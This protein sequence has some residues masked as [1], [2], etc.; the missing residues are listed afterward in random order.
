M[1][2]AVGGAQV[3]AREE[4]GQS[5][6]CSRRDSTTRATHGRGKPDLGLH[7]HSGCPHEPRA[8]YRTI[9]D[10]AR[11]ESAR[12]PA[13]ADS[14][15]VVADVSASALGSDHRADFFTTEVWTCEASRCSSSMI[16]RPGAYRSSGPRH[17][18]TTRYAPGC[19]DAFD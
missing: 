10:R 2:P 7:A 19:P 16:S 12:C 13:G 11:A 1:V 8:P 14:P 18:R 3:D 6:R 15:D 4:A 17:I 5:F 9:D